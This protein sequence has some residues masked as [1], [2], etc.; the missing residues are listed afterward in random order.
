[1]S[2]SHIVQGTTKVNDTY[3][4]TAT[5]NTRAWR[6]LVMCQ[7]VGHTFGLDHQDE[8]FNNPNLGSC[9]DSPTI[10]TVD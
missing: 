10:Q 9:M 3:F 7:E 5:Y 6:Q 2:G 1:V 4:N 8:T